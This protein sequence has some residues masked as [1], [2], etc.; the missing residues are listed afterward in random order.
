MPHKNHFKVNILGS[1]TSTGVPVIGCSCE[2]CTSFNP[3]D[4][5]TRSSI[6]IENKANNKKIL[7]DATP[8]L[9]AQFLNNK[10]TTTDYLLFTHT[11]ADHCHGFDDLRPLF[12][13][14][15]A[16]PIKVWA[17]ET[18]LEE[19]QRRFF[20]IFQQTGYRGITPILDTLNHEQVKEE[21]SSLDFE[22]Y[23]LPHGLTESTAFRWGNFAYATDFK[24]FPKAI[25]EAWK[26][27]I[28]VMIASGIMYKSHHSHSSIPET[29][30]LFEELG[31]KQGYITH[32]SHVVLHERDSQKLPPH[33]QFAYDGQVIDF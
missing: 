28:E 30:A 3:K 14:K 19:L 27:K 21:F 7:I 11:H 15:T 8:D 6:Y 18:H 12:F 9:R 33:I 32:I 25:I 29:V 31:V 16:K 2:V 13:N 26:G 1:G 4:H 17:T 20:Y 23:S 22:Y 5:R 24:Q 10:I